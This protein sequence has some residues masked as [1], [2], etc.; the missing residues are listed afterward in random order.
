[1]LT[2]DGPKVLEFNCRF[3]DPETQAVLRLLES[4]LF[5]IMQACVS[6]GLKTI[7]IEY[8]NKVAVA[9]VMASAGYPSSRAE[10]VPIYGIESAEKQ[11]CVVFHA[12]TATHVGAATDLQ[13]NLR[14]NPRTCDKH[15]V[16]QTNGG[17]VL[18]VT[19]VADDLEMA[20]DRAHQGVS[21]I[22]FEGSQ[23]RSDIG[24][25]APPPPWMR[26]PH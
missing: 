3:G 5:E 24:R 26:P 2:D 22:T 18:A 6:G 19:A 25:N 11:G 10:P 20:A 9:V 4:D 14:T 16:L 7:N 13:P 8:S 12:G 21:S 1:M 23:H 15:S 17:R